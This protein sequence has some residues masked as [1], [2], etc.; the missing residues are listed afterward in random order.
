MPVSVDP[1][2]LVID[3]VAVEYPAPTHFIGFELDEWPDG[4]EEALFSE[5]VFNVATRAHSSTCGGCE[6]KCSKPVIAR[7]QRASAV[8]T[9]YIEC[10]E[11]PGHGT[12]P[13]GLEQLRRYQVS[14]RTLARWLIKHLRLDASRIASIPDGL[15]LGA[16]RG[17]YEKRDISLLVRDERFLLLVGQQEQELS[18]IISWQK[19]AS[20]VDTRQI[21]RL[22]NRKRK[23]PLASKKL[24]E[25]VSSTVG[26]SDLIAE[27]NRQIR[28]H[29]KQLRKTGKSWPTISQEIA[30]MPFIA[31]S[32][33][34]L[35]PI[36]ACTVR[37]I[38]AT[39][40]SK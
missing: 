32:E 21:M 34:G 7:R 13:V 38:L 29:G 31:S 20:A 27:R 33:Q 16:I 2:R 3:R 6:R 24:D 23:L 22:V 37:R 30:R 26:H 4:A 35:K 8:L 18:E 12:I 39:P 28:S 36:Q 9:A 19:H 1:I 5:G 10:D 15:W 25:E 14:L 40:A 11:E 17:R